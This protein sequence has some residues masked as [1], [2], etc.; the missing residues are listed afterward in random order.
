MA[1]PS[2]QE[3]ADAIKQWTIGLHQPPGEVFSRAFWGSEQELRG[4]YNL[5]SERTQ[6]FLQWEKQFWGMNLGYTDDASA[7][8]AR[9]RARWFVARSTNDTGPIRYGEPV[10]I[11]FGTPPSFIRYKHRSDPGIDLDWSS[12]QVFEWKILGG[13]LNDAVKVGDRVALYNTKVPAGNEV[14]DFLIYFDREAGCD[15]GWTTSSTLIDKLKRRL[16]EK[17][18]PVAR[19]AV[20]AAFGLP[21]L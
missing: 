16:L 15:I 17:L 10:S 8:T 6:R 20:L 7:E 1:E 13:K 2:T 14:G 12:T 21:P 3:I 18:G 11:G 19:K 9:K 5:Y 4:K